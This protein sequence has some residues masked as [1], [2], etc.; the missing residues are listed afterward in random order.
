MTELTSL[1]VLVVLFGIT[2]AIFD[3]ATYRNSLSGGLNIQLGRFKVPVW[4]LLI[5]IGVLW[6]II[7]QVGSWLLGSIVP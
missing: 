2:V 7:D 1:G 3:R 5:L 6:I 4:Y